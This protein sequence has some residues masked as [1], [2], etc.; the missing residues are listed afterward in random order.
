MGDQI[1]AMMTGF[2]ALLEENRQLRQVVQT[3]QVGDTV[4]GQAALRYNRRCNTAKGGV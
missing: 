1:A 4:I 3:I 2:E